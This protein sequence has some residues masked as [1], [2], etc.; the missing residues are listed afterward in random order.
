MRLL[1]TISE[2]CSEWRGAIGRVVRLQQGYQ[3]SD[4]WQSQYQHAAESLPGHVSVSPG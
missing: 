2:L 4:E 1:L 3:N